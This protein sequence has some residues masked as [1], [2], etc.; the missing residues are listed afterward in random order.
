MI[1]IDN[2]VLISNFNGF[3]INL[4]LKKNYKSNYFN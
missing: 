3:K 1:K 4:N 2:R